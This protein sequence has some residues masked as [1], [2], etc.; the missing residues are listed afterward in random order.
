MT[1]LTEDVNGIN[2]GAAD[3]GAPVVAATETID[4]QGAPIARG[5]R[6]GGSTLFFLLTNS[7]PRARRLRNSGGTNIVIQTPVVRRQYNK[8]WFIAARGH[9]GRP[10]WSHLPKSLHTVRRGIRNWR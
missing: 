4:M 10:R 9:T 5:S 8:R 3:R 6:T 7:I 2:V 1:E